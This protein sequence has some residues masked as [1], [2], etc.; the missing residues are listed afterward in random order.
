MLKVK[1]SSFLFEK[2]AA[3]HYGRN[4]KDGVLHKQQTAYFIALCLD[5]KGRLIAQ[6]KLHNHRYKNYNVN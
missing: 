6:S 4:T 1:L 2:E 5:S 3:N